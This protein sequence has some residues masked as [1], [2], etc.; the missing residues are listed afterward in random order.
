MGSPVEH[1]ILYS[2]ACTGQNR[3]QTVAACLL[4]SVATIPN[5]EIIDHKF[6]ERGHIHMECDS[7]H[8]AI[9]FAN[10]KTKIFTP[11]QWETVISM[12]RRK[13]PYRVVMLKHKDFKGFKSMTYKTSKSYKTESGQKPKWTCMK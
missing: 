12:A 9:E 6:L 4:H 1:V 2:D 3:N 7:M 10:S 11:S 8:A 5:I 13:N